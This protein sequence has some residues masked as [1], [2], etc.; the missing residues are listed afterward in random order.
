MR[1]AEVRN[2]IEVPKRKYIYEFE[3]FVKVGAYFEY[4]DLEISWNY[5]EMEI[6]SITYGVCHSKE[7]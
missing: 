6:I 4:N 2:N 5:M 1:T 3:V 7:T